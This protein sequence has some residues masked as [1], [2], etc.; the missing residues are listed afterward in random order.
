LRRPRAD[1]LLA[2]AQ[3]VLLPLQAS[4]ASRS[5]PTKAKQ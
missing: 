4:Q 1:T 2:T 3:N 5:V